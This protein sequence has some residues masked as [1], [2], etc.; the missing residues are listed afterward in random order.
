MEVVKSKILGLSLAILGWIGA[1]VVCALP[2][3]KVTTT[4]RLFPAAESITKWEGIWKSCKNS[5]GEK[6]CEI[7]DYSTLSSDLQA[8]RPLCI[9]VIVMGGLGLL[10]FIVGAKCCDQVIKVSGCTF[11]CAAVLLFIPVCWAAYSTIKA[12]FKPVT[13]PGIIEVTNPIGVS[14]YLGWASS[15][16]LFGGGSILGC[17]CLSASVLDF[18]V[19]TG[20]A[21]LS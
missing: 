12:F 11:I 5:T 9:I 14:L 1:I 6:L 4:V 20:T 17:S 16:L 2:M 10:F 15:A 21:L 8:A 18:V 7:Q 13:S 19:K 3:W